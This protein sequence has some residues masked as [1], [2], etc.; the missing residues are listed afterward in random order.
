MRLLEQAGLVDVE[1]FHIN[2]DLLDRDRDEALMPYFKQLFHREP[3]NIS[4]APFPRRRGA[5]S[6]AGTGS[7]VGSSLRGCGERAPGVPYRRKH[8]NSQVLGLV[9]VSA[10]LGLLAGRYLLAGA[11]LDHIES[12]VLVAGWQYLQGNPLYLIDA[13]QPAF[14]VFYG[15]LAFLAPLPFAVFTGGTVWGSKLGSFLA[16]AG[17]VGLMAWHFLRRG[18]TG[19]GRDGAL[20][21]DDRALD[22]VSGQHLAAPRSL[23]G[24]PGGR[25]RCHVEGALR[26]R[27]LPAYASGWR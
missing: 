1:A 27:R 14:A 20:L 8:W 13:G 24:L 9:V 23:R 25:R 22:D 21:P 7:Y 10:L 15:P 5:I 2:E 26:T 6:N 16:L 11:Y 3:S 12:T 4:A 19:P 17:T 18:W